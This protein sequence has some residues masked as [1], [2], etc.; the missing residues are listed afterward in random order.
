MDGGDAAYN[1]GIATAIF[2]GKP[3]AYRDLVLLNAGLRTYLAERAETVEDG[4]GKAREAI[5]SGAAKAKLNA[6]RER[7]SVRSRKP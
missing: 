5:D 7:A 2:E 3:G 6:L 4:I 1:A